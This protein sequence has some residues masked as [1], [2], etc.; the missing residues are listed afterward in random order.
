M[1]CFTVASIGVLA[2]HLVQYVYQ[3]FYIFK[4][5]LFYFLQH[6]FDF[7]SIFGPI[8]TSVCLFAL[9]I[10]FDRIYWIGL[11]IFDTKAIPSEMFFLL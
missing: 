2:Q 1:N 5:L 10:L 4:W 9:S 3:Y 6:F 7:T 8:F 11:V